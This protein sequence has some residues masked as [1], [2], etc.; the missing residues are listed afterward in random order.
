MWMWLISVS[1][2]LMRLQSLL[3]WL[4]RSSLWCHVCVFSPFLNDLISAQR[5]N[6][7]PSFLEKSLSLTTHNRMIQ[8]VIGC[9]NIT[10][11]G[12]R[13]AVCVLLSSGL[14]MTELT[15]TSVLSSQS[16]NV[17]CN[18]QLQPIVIP[19]IRLKDLLSRP[20]SHL[21]AQWKLHS[22]PDLL[23]HSSPCL[24]FSSSEGLWLLTGCLR[25]RTPL[26]AQVWK[27]K[28]W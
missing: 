18:P 3:D 11:C 4:F 16:K 23:W 15:F 22:I 6:P 27:Q 9:L 2:Y 26:N 7:D 28:C 10:R 19:R 20:F 14:Q 25:S 24:C 5:P 13:K 21:C 1:Y 17:L 8:K 12:L